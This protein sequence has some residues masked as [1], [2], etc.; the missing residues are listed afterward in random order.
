MTSYEVF[1]D[2]KKQL[3]FKNAFSS[4]SV[5]IKEAGPKTK[6]FNLCILK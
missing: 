3:N 5:A 2:S 6:T 4:F 1:F